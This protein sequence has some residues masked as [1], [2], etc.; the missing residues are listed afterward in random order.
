MYKITRDLAKFFVLIACF[1]VLSFAQETTGGIEGTV[2]DANGA[3]VPNISITI[4]TTAGGSAV[5]G[6]AGFRRTLTSDVSGFFRATQ[7]PPGTYDVIASASSGFGEAKYSNVVV[8]IG[9][10]TPITIEMKPGGN[11]VTV[12]VSASDTA[13]IDTTNN[14]IQT[15]INAAK[16]E[17]LPKGTGF[18][19]VL[20]SVPGTRPES[21]TAGFSVDGASGGENVFVIDGQEVTNYRT[22]TLNETYNIPTQLVREVQVKSS[23][24]DAE[25]GGATGGVVS[26]V[27]KGGTNG[28]HGEVGIAVDSAKMA[29][30]GRDLLQRFTSGTVGGGNFVQTSETFSPQKAGGDNYYPS[31]TIGGPILKDRVWF[32]G[33][34]SPQIQNTEVTTQYFTN[35]PAATRTFVTT[36]DYSRKRTYNY[37]FGRIDTNPMDNL[38]ITSTFLWNPVVDEGSIPGTS[39]S[40]V[41]SSAIGFGNVPTASY[42]GSIGVLTGNQYT[43]RQGGRQSSNLFTIDGVYTPNASVVITGRYSRGFLNEKNGNYF[44][45]ETTQIFACGAANVNF[46]CATTAANTVTRKDVSV[47]QAYDFAVGYAFVSGFRHDLKVGYQRFSIFNDVVTGNSTVGR[48][49]YNY[50]TPISTLLGGGITDTP[51]AVGSGS[52]RRTGSRGLAANRN[53]A[54]FIQDKM[55][56]TSRLTLNLGVRVEK[57]N[58]PTYNQFPSTINF[59]WNDKVAPRVGGAYDLFGDGQTKI[60]ASYGRFFDRIKFELPRGLFGGDIF[61]EDYFEIFPNT[62]STF[63]NITNIVNGY[64][65][66]SICPNSG[67]ITP[68]AL[69]RCQKNLRVNSNDPNATAFA[70]GAIDP[71]LEPFRQ[72]EFTF[73]VEHQLTPGYVL[74]TRYTYKNVDQA[75]E[76]AGVIQ[77]ANEAYIIG[78]P[79][80]GLHFETLKNLGYWKAAQPQRRY[81]ALE[82]VL[83]RRFAN[84]W[85]F[86]ANYTWSRLYGNYSGLASSDE[87]H[88]VGGRTSPGVSRAFDLPFIGFTAKGEPDNGLL[89]TDRTHVFNIY[90]TYAFNWFGSK[91]NTT[92]I[93]AFQTVTSGTPMTTS[94]FG[95]STVTPQI[96]NERGDLGRSPMITQTDLS[97]SHK[98]KFG[99]D[100]R[101]KAIFDINFLNLWDQATVT[102]IYP[103]MNPSS[104]PVNAAAVSGG[105]NTNYANG[106]TSGTLYNAILARIAS[107][108]DRSDVRYRQPQLFQGPRSVRYGVRFVF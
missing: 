88:L 78:N 74:R 37:A 58:L 13:P 105:N 57:E 90:G 60:F 85:F 44:V 70:G 28:F 43:S 96:F 93:S 8:V 95:A 29:G 69:S 18:T 9:R 73:G 100:G 45:P 46:P 3:V 82:F 104:A 6:N 16:M 33:S 80:Q 17:L 102:G 5:T 67:V 14:A 77:G 107:Q 36:Q 48:V 91:S 56:P 64:T 71:N 26:V 23:G 50:G 10:S 53:Q 2:Q 47:R 89:P 52:F 94:I 19:S 15:S 1:A 106:Y 84:N 108:A 103:T 54:V 11:V 86:N 63:F 25:F 4:T 35:A 83:E 49:S 41:T 38:R 42:G 22:G 21:R 68:G 51:G 87:A 72:T 98:V 81:D 97:L 75:V 12:D 40:N 101:F 32:F 61:L 31:V 76:D 55:Q 79:G 59:G 27:T 99:N 62:P 39:F 30:K 65:G 92:D 34:Y 66:P 24:F 20:R 7:V